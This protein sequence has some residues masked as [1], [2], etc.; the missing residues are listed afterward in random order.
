MSTNPFQ[1]ERT[2]RISKTV[3]VDPSTQVGFMIVPKSPTMLARA[4]HFS[5]LLQAMVR[6]VQDS[7]GVPSIGS[8][9]V[10]LLQF[11]VEDECCR[12]S[13]VCN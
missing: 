10:N 4:K 8:S 6:V 1:E 2:N 13:L 5:E 7:V 12:P 11:K 9:L 3:Q